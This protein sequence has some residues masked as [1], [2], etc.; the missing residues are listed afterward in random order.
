[1]LEDDE[2]KEHEG[3]KEE[4]IAT[5]AFVVVA[6]VATAGAFVGLVVVVVVIT[7]AVGVVVDM[8]VDA[9]VVEPASTTV[10]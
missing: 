5:K 10:V 8:V 3:E 1:M 4:V 6:G 2:D 9:S 7:T